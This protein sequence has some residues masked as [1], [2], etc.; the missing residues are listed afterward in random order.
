[1]PMNKKA[2]LEGLLFVVGEEGLAAKELQ[3]ILEVSEYELQKL[4]SFLDEDYK[5]EDRGIQ[6]AFL[7][8]CY[9]LVTKQEHKEYYKKLITIEE[10]SK[11]SDAALETLAIIAYNEPITRVQ[12]DE[13]RGVS[14]VHHVRKLLLKNLIRE[15]GKSD[16]PGRPILYG[17]TK[18]FLDY[19][20]LSTIEDLP[21]ITIDTEDLKEQ[22]D[23]FESKYK[24]N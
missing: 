18:E 16:L 11:L 12:I 8:N 7:G 20:G 1:M 24:E 17:V 9:K 13:I 21:K 15:V 22:I 6:I 2:I 14:S 5:K 3:S 10:N 4:I 23:L 19:F